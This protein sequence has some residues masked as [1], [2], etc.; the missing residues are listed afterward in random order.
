M[1]PLAALLALA[2]AHGAWAGDPWAV[3][4]GP[5]RIEGP[6]EMGAVIQQWV[7]GFQQEH[8]GTPVQVHLAG[9]DV[10]LGALTTGRADIAFAG[11]SAAPQELKAFEWVFRYPP[12]AVTVLNGSLDRPGA[13]NALVV[14]VHRDNPLQAITFAQLRHLLD[15]PHQWQDAGVAGRLAP[16]PI[17]FYLPDAESGTGVFLRHR[18]L[19]DTRA[20]PWDQVTEIADSAERGPHRHDAGDRI[21]RQVARDPLALAV[22]PLPPQLPPQVKVLAVATGA[23]DA[24]LRPSVQDVIAGGYPL[25][26][27]VRAYVNAAPARPADP[28]RAHALDRDVAAFLDHALGPDGQGNVDAAAGFLPLAPASAVAARERLDAMQ[29]TR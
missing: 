17:H 24:P 5:L 16:R 2:F 25:A 28:S 8:P 15:G 20:L 6:P 19:A 12:T 13:A 3:R 26:R 27:E 11:R 18:V 1:K 10:G 22:A 29:A 9:T 7:R 4:T 23:D 14:L 21:A